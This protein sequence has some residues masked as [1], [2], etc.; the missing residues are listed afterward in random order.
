MSDLAARYDRPLPRYTSYP[1]AVHWQALAAADVEDTL[2]RAAACRDPLSLYVHIPFCETMC[3]YCGCHVIAGRRTERVDQYLHALHGQIERLGARLQHR[4]AAQ[5]HLGGGTP[6]YLSAAELAALLGALE[7]AFPGD[8]HTKRSVEIDPAVTG[9]DQLATLGAYGFRRLSVGVQ[10]I[11]P[12]VLHRVGRAGAADTLAGLVRAARD[13]GFDS[14]NAD[15]MYGLPGQDQ[16]HVAES[17]RAVADLGFDRVALFGYAHVPWLRPNQRRLEACA[18]PDRDLR[19]A[20]AQ[21]GRA[22]LAAR[23]YQSVGMDHFARPGDSLGEAAR[24]GVVRRNFQGYTA[25]EPGDLLGLGVSAISDIQG[26]YLQ[27]CTRLSDYIERAE[28]GGAP[29]VRG[30]RRSSEDERRRALIEGLMSNMRAT[31]TDPPLAPLDPLIADGLCAQD[32]T[33]LSVTELGRPLVRNVAALFD[34][35]ISPDDRYSRAV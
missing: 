11:D 19:W 27:S 21:A 16:R 35:Y 10:E 12:E 3:S 24:A 33:A 34:A 9:L 1:T 22:A 23:G 6:T 29:L 30:W 20:M 14:L 5:V 4:T 32:G 18:L 13:Y 2:E 25:D 17:C 15:L 8:G 7:R 26:T 31:L 28:A